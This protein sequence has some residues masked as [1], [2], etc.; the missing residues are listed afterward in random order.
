MCLLL[1]EWRT[2]FWTPR[3]S[4]SCL[5]FV[6]FFKYSRDHQSQRLCFVCQV[7]TEMVIPWSDGTIYSGLQ[8]PPSRIPVYSRC[9]SSSRQLPH[10]PGQSRWVSWIL[11]SCWW[12]V[13]WTCVQW[14]TERNGKSPT[15]AFWTTWNDVNNSDW[16]ATTFSSSP[17]LCYSW[18][19]ADCVFSGYVSPG[20]T[21]GSATKSE[22]IDHVASC[23]NRAHKETSTVITVIENMVTKSLLYAP[24]SWHTSSLGWKWEC[25]RVKVW[26]YSSNY[27]QSRR[28]VACW[29]MFGHLWV[30]E[31]ATV[32]SINHIMYRRPHV[33]CRTYYHTL[34][35]HLL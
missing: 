20:S 8:G 4:G 14:F 28:Q 3:L 19:D 29:G 35:Q 5:W 9:H 12:L 18:I 30:A 33:C 17:V 1:V 32:L 24:S 16:H 26:G 25:S 21:V 34:L 7:S 6:Y 2:Q 11:P 31:Y 22:S 23:L 27:Q 15:C 13:Y 10:Q